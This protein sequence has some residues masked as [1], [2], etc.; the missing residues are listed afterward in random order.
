VPGGFV[1]ATG[2]NTAGPTWPDR[3]TPLTLAPGTFPNQPGITVFNKNYNNPRIYS[4]N[5]NYSQQ[6]APDWAG[7]I[8]LAG[9]QRVYLT[10]CV[11]PNGGS[12]VT[13]T[14]IATT[15]PSGS[16]F[17]KGV[18][19]PLNGDA[20]SYPGPSAFANLGSVTDTQSSAHSLYRGM[21]IGA[22]KRL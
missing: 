17:S 7:Y 20:V 3:I 12:L 4:A 15:C 13:G 21:T 1:G 11:D 10:R 22:R 18:C 8:D 9:A 5:L 19:I 16:T 6:L 14:P 2:F